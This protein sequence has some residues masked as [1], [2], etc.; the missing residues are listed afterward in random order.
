MAMPVPRLALAGGFNCE[1]SGTAVARA[2][3]DAGVEHLVYSSSNAAGPGTGVGY[4]ESKFQVEEYVRGL[5]LD[6]TIVRPSTFMEL[7]LMPDFGLS[8]GRLTFF[9]RPDQA[10]QFIA[11]QDIGNVVKRVFGERD[12]HRN[13]TIEIAGDSVTGEDL[14]ARI[15]LVAGRPISYRRFP[16][17]VLRDNRMLARLAALVDEGPLAG[18]ADLGALR[19]RYPGL[20]GFDS[21]L[22]R[23]NWAA[24]SKP[25]D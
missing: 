14:A 20:L 13:P 6:T 16:D 4:F 23:V 7:L 8:Q 17:S 12:A 18:A 21:W 2:A 1:R 19:Q 5:P 11:V 3:R 22:A 15:S 25:T 24:D 10:M 9:M